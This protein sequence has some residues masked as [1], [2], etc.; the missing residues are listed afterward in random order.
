VRP[1]NREMPA[2]NGVRVLIVDDD[3]HAREMVTVALEHCGAHVVAVASAAEAKR[4][5]VRSACDVLLVD[6]AMPGKDGYTFVREMRS[7]A[8]RTE[9]V[10][11][12]LGVAASAGPESAEPEPVVWESAEG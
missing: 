9:A 5:L 4:V 8:L 10:A 1:D 12:E 11:R 6:L 2:L 3:A 7:G